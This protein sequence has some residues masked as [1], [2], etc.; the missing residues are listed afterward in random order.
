MPDNPPATATS[1]TSLAVWI[2]LAGVC[3]TVLGATLSPV[4]NYFVNERQMD[5]K[6]VEI[7]IGILRAPPVEDIAVIRSWAVDVIEKSSGRKFT[8]AQRAALLKTELPWVDPGFTDYAPSRRKVGNEGSDTNLGN[9]PIT[10][11]FPLPP[12]K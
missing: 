11:R 9:K 3:G 8:E 4:V 6:M 1:S 5:V 12:K 10:D 7:G 2:S